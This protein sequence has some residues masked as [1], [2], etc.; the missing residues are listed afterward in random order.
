M[1]DNF[2]KNEI[3]AKQPANRW[4]G[5]IVLAIVFGLCTTIC[6]SSAC[7]SCGDYLRHH[8]R[9]GFQLSKTDFAQSSHTVPESS[10]GCKNGSCRSQI[11]PT[12]ATL[13]DRLSVEDRSSDVA[14]ARQQSDINLPFN[15]LSQSAICLLPQNCLEVAVPPP[16]HSS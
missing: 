4:S 16:R 9:A 2:H 13:P 5:S 6:S 1:T 11:P 3:D 12:S 15:R 10:P 7:A 14:L 8:G